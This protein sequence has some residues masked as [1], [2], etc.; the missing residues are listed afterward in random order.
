MELK[1]YDV[2]VLGGGPGGQR[3]A[4]QAA[5]ENASVALIDRKLRM[6]GVC[7]HTGTI[8]S[9]TLREAVMNMCGL[10][11]TLYLDG[12]KRMPNKITLEDLMRRVNK[13]L[14]HEMDVVEDQLSRNNVCNVPGTARFIDAHT[15]EV[16]ASDNEKP[17]G[18][19]RGEKII[20]ATG[21]SPRRPDDIPFDQEVIYDSNFIFSSRSKRKELP[22]S[23]IVIG[24]GV[25]GTEYACIM[26]ALGC[27]VLLVDPREEPFE[28]IDRDMLHY[29]RRA[30][31]KAGME[32][33]F[34]KRTEKVMRTPD[35]RARVEL[36]TGE[37]LEADAVLFAIGR[38]PSTQWLGLE[39]INLEM[40]KRGEVLVNEHFQT[41]IP[42]IYAVGDVIGFPALASTSSEQGLRA[43]RHALGLPQ[44][45][46]SDLL[47][48]AIYTIP[49]VSMVG[50][51]EKQLQEEGI[52]YEKGVALYNELAKAAII[53]D[54]TGALKILFAKEDRRILG[55]HIVGNY[56]AEIIHIGQI[57]MQCKATLD[58]FIRNVFNYP[59][60]SVAYKVAA[61]NG[62]NVIEGHTTQHEI[63]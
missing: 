33:H 24:G 34:S 32:F 4:V 19:F 20:I 53:G 45:G 54:T 35:G 13:V 12:E 29:L 50:K 40:T 49:E 51:S 22:E 30:M 43:A 1:K 57:A 42:N 26:R 28:F 41:N 31:E 7:L 58:I 21:T 10:R 17:F 14:I 62:I 11:Q 15:V 8:P 16:H 46:G 59:T 55:V 60:L 23:L 52:E 47:P 27:R 38:T 44:L 39:N 37:V 48:F 63:N 56:S 9:K 25:I 6:G 5:K 61:L 36:D 3:A 2:L 18:L